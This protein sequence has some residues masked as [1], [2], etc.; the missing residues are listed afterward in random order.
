MK[1][2]MSFVL[3]AL[4]C[5]ASIAAADCS[6]APPAD[7]EKATSQYRLDCTQEAL[8]SD[9]LEIITAATT[10]PALKA[11]VLPLLQAMEPTTLDIIMGVA[12]P[13]FP[14]FLTS[15]SDQEF[16]Q[17]RP[18]AARYLTNYGFGGQVASRFTTS[19][20]AGRVSFSES[21][22][23][24]APTLTQVGNDYFLSYPG[25]GKVKIDKNMPQGTKI[26][27][28]PTQL[29]DPSKPHVP[30]KLVIV[31]PHPAST[32]PA[33]AQ[34][35]IVPAGGTVSASGPTTQWFVL[36]KE[37]AKIE[38]DPFTLSE[39]DV[40]AGRILLVGKFGQKWSIP[41][42]VE[43][44]DG[45]NAPVDVRVQAT[46]GS[47]I[48]HTPATLPAPYSVFLKNAGSDKHATVTIAP[49]GVMT[50]FTLERGTQIDGDIKVTSAS[51]LGN[52]QASLSNELAATNALV[53]KRA[54]VLL[55]QGKRSEALDVLL[56]GRE[57]LSVWLGEGNP[58]LPQHAQSVQIVPP[59]STADGPQVVLNNRAHVFVDNDA[60]RTRLDGKIDGMSVGLDHQP[61]DPSGRPKVSVLS[62]RTGGI[63]AA[64][65]EDAEDQFIVFDQARF[66]F[67]EDKSEYEKN[68]K[69]LEAEFK[70]R[71]KLIETEIKVELE[72]KKAARDMNLKLASAGAER[73]AIKK[74]YDDAKR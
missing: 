8:Q 48:V 37:G 12:G 74:T 59:T 3:I 32:N 49:F 64:A 1:R 69:Q 24:A 65:L 50:A 62:L 54:A 36:E 16:A 71:I 17:T 41:R 15:L 42:G 5:A 43:L 63:R 21:L 55:S 68:K 9:P 4:L 19:T 40:N 2:L 60:R 66:A 10:D 70:Q 46:S 61:S 28:Q 51:R 33:D 26:L 18:A 58:P 47:V 38:F 57:K 67:D 45:T 25:G 20:S 56:A 11:K 35:F 13:Q 53:E 14:A 6:S 22:G 72:G 23:V 52:V 39:A 7:D 30:G 31:T 73:D 44:K 29:P 27:T 34:T